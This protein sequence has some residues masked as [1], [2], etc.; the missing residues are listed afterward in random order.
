M[1]TRS[2]NI[3]PFLFVYT[4]LSLKPEYVGTHHTWVNFVVYLW[5]GAAG[6]VAHRFLPRAALIWFPMARLSIHR[7]AAPRI[8]Q[9]RYPC[10]CFSSD[11][12]LNLVVRPEN[13]CWRGLR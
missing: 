2:V 10:I 5:D 13:D 3:C 11:S 1:L 4:S 6:S 12:I 7:Q 8:P 9:Y